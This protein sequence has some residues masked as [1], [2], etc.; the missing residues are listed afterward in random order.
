MKW[1]KLSVS[2]AAWGLPW[3]LGRHVETRCR[4]DLTGPPGCRSP[5]PDLLGN[6]TPLCGGRELS[7]MGTPCAVLR[8]DGNLAVTHLLSGVM[9]PHPGSPQPWEYVPL[10][11]KRK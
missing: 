10:P 9:P 7:S 6:D 1:F 8:A 11:H 4:P 5:W 2:H 3:P